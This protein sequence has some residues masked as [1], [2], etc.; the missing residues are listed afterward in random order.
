VTFKCPACLADMKR[1]SSWLSRCENC[2]LYVSKLSPGP[3]KAF[4]GIE[5]L[6]RQNFEMVL[7][8]IEDIRPLNG[9]RLLEVG[10]AKGWF[11]QAAKSR[12]AIVSGIEPVSSD[13]EVARSSG[14]D[15]EEGLFPDYPTDPGPY[16]LIV[17]N[18][19]FEHIP[20]PAEAAKAA[21]DLLGRDGLLVINIPSSRGV[22]FRTASLL[23]KAGIP[24]PYDRMWQRGLPSP[25]MTYFSPD[26]LKTLIERHTGLRRWVSKPLPS[27]DRSGLR[28]RIDSMQT[29]VPSGI[30]YAGAWVLSFVASALA[31]DIE[32]SIFTKGKFFRS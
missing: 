28:Q 23:N 13:A 20:N 16:D 30:V 32:L 9:Q 14:L 15:I 11:L 19:V 22:I 17:F 27:L 3:G 26:N 18:D 29:G 7:N 24:G 25:H 31:S 1:R 5:R 6:R 10:S 12:G 4:E 2:G 8:Q 21:A